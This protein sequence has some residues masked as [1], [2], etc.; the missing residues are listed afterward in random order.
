MD[1]SALLSARPAGTPRAAT[2]TE[3]GDLPAGFQDVL[4]SAAAQG[5]SPADGLTLLAGARATAPEA[6]PSPAAMIGEALLRAPLM[7]AAS[8]ARGAEVTGDGDRPE[9]PATDD[10]VPTAD[11]E[12]VLNPLT[13]APAPQAQPGNPTGDAPATAPLAAR[14]PD[15]AGAAAR[16]EPRGE[17]RAANDLAINPAADGTRPE[18]RPAGDA[19]SAPLKADAGVPPVVNEA[20]T[21]RTVT[22]SEG[23][24]PTATAATHTPAPAS[25]A[26]PASTTVTLQ[27][28]VASQAWGQELG[29]QL[30]SVARH[31]EQR[32]ELH[33]N[34]RD[35]GPMSVSLKVDDQGAQAHFFSSHAAVRGAL[36]QALPQL[37]EALAQQGIALGEA[38]VGDQPRQFSGGAGGGDGQGQPG[39]ATSMAAA[40]PVDDATVT[41][42]VADHRADDGGVDL[43]A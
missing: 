4:A 37:R 25:P 12:A 3:G 24:A 27:A 10:P 2:P 28:P 1:I 35:L 8:Q 23:P 41:A 26:A 11:P 7:P 43:Y 31:G 42:P 14:V 17:A 13:T 30:V 40:E 29:Q 15:A 6:P 18:G 22:S 5:A 36:E 9:P 34:P 38:M 21:A 39:A 32:M 16:G 33:L 20:P 19:S